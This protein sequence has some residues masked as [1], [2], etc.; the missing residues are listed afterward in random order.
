M[1]FPEAPLGGLTL[2]YDLLVPIGALAA[3]PAY[4]VRSIGRPEYR[5]HLPERMGRLPAGLR[6]ELERLAR[7]PIWMQAVSVG[8]VILANHLGAALAAAACGR[9]LALPI[10]V[11]S[12]TPAGRQMAASSR[13]PGL[14]GV[15]HFPIDWPPFVSRALRAVRPCAF[16]SI[17]TELWP[18]FLSR[19]GAAGVPALMVNGRISERSCRRYRRLRGLMSAPLQSIR[20][21][22]M[23]SGQ[24]A[25]R[26]RL[27]G[28]PADRI[29]VTGNIKFDVP[30]AGVS[31]AQLRQSYGIPEDAPVLV[32]GSTSP[33]EEELV[34]DAVRECGMPGLTLLLAPRHRE[35]FDQVARLMESRGVRFVRR[36]RLPAGR[37][38]PGEA[39]LLDT[40][41]E[42]AGAYAVASV[43]F[44]GGSLVPRGGQ[45]PIEP[46]A[47]G[48]PVLV[49]P[50]TENFAHVAASLLEAGAAFRVGGARELGQRVK[51]LIG[52]EVDRI[53]VGAAGQALVEANRGA[54]AR[55]VEAVLPFVTGDAGDGPR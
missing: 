48:V 35:R 5:S 37:R 14:A 34:L 42:L 8:E 49:G 11:S 17:E 50:H 9:G 12:T 25:E 43:A 2:L 55:T 46:A 6:E 32:A 38:A 22:C 18:A 28:I 7:R 26:A 51:E 36:S 13:L 30:P 20:L 41:G 21:A 15:F 40:M 23:Q 3:A 29:V 10:V 45:N 19:C 39:I 31:C 4:L 33:G 44:V 53:R 1:R 52:S 47:C 24:D 54:T 16:I 27:I